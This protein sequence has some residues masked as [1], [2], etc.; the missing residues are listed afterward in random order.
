M[1]DMAIK[2]INPLTKTLGLIDKESDLGK[3]LISKNSEN[4]ANYINKMKHDE[5]KTIFNSVEITSAKFMQNCSLDIVYKM[6]K[7]DKILTKK[8]AALQKDEGSS[9]FSKFKKALSNTINYISGKNVSAKEFNAASEDIRQIGERTE[10]PLVKIK[11][12][13]KAKEH[14][15]KFTQKITAE[16]SA[17]QNSSHHI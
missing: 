7:V 4:I 6:S 1:Y 3:M 8:E 5:G 12:T 14:L 2:E 10:V 11:D 15:G 17:H 16:R 9:F 13:H